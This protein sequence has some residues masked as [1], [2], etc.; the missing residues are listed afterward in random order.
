[1]GKYSFRRF[2]RHLFVPVILLAGP[3]RSRA[4]QSAFAGSSP[5]EPKS[6]I[7]VA[8]FF[9]NPASF[10]REAGPPQP[11]L[12]PM[13]PGAISPILVAVIPAPVGKSAHRFWNRENR[14]LFAA[15]GALAAADFYTTRR[16]LVK[17][18]K[19][20]NPVTRVFAANTP[21]LASNFALETGGVIAI[22]YL[23]HKSGHHKLE[24]LTSYVNVAV[25]ASA[26]GYN[27]THH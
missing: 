6:D 14:I 23:F 20:L 17:N 4:Q 7:L 24:H 22:S 2:V 5:G 21:A 13:R 9:A 8:E 11:S 3:C 18:G 26:V 15:N 10:A 16:N 25:S 1:M 27:I 19:E 12:Q